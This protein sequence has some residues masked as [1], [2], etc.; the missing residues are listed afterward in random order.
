MSSWEVINS[1]HY[2]QATGVPAACIVPSYG[3]GFTSGVA[4][5]KAGTGLLLTVSAPRL[6]FCG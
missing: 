3:N 6:N 4:A 5:G 2:H 1:C